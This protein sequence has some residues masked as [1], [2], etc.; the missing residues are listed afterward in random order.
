[1]CYICYMRNKGQNTIEYILLV[2]A[3]LSVLIIFLKP[4]GRYH[5]AVENAVLNSTVRQM[6]ALKDELKPH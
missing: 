6:E 4:Q 3:V 1:M 2:V 5:H